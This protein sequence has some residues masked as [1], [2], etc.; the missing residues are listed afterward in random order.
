MATNNDGMGGS[1]IEHIALSKTTLI[2]VQS[3]NLL[4]SIRDSDTGTDMP[5][6]KITKKRGATVQSKK[7]YDCKYIDTS[8][9]SYGGQ[10]TLGVGNKWNIRVGSGGIYTETTGPLLFR[11]Q[12]TLFRSKA[13]F[14]V[15]TKLFQACGSER[16]DLRGKKLNLAFQDIVVQGN[17]N[18]FNNVSVNGGLYVNGQVI[19][20]HLTTQKCTYVTD[21]SQEAKGLLNPGQSFH[22][23]NGSSMAAKKYVNEGLL[24]GLF[25]ALDVSDSDEKLQGGMVDIELFLNLDWLTQIIPGLD[26]IL[27]QIHIP[28]KIAFPKGISLISDEMDAQHPELYPIV[29]SIERPIGAG[30]DRP[31]LMLPGHCHTYKGPACSLKDGTEKIYTEGAKTLQHELIKHKQNIGNGCENWQ[32]FKNQF[33]EAKTKEIKNYLMKTLEQ[34]NPFSSITSSATQS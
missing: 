10:Y 21:S 4:Q 16:V 24:S 11:P 18:F 29:S 23:F 32:D 6:T 28:C 27:R 5:F 13:A 30:I 31:D 3:P 1:L 22:I 34:F 25:N 8:W 12:F 2:G 33:I 14:C 20:P 19:C 17:T 15:T 7:E 9:L 26:L